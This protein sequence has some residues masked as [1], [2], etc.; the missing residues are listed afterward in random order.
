M[1]FP[2]GVV[3]RGGLSL[4]H[5]SLASSAAESLNAHPTRPQRTREDTVFSHLLAITVVPVEGF[6]GLLAC[7]LSLQ[8][9]QIIDPFP[10]AWEPVPRTLNINSL[11]AAVLLRLEVLYRIH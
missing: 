6:L 10:I 3:K 11:W 1:A 7:F 9:N 2:R 4:P 8:I 5:T